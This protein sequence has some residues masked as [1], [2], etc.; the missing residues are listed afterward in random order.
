MGEGHTPLSL[1]ACQSSLS[2][3]HKLRMLKGWERDGV[4]LR[5][6]PGWVYSHLGDKALGRSGRA[7]AERFTEEGR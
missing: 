5:C 7:L 2:A 3:K 4:G 6:G 1:A